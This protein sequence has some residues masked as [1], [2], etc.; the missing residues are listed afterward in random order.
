LAATLVTS[1]VGVATFLV[2]SA[3]NHGSIAPDW[4][5]GIALG[6]GGLVGGYLGAMAQP[7]LPDRIIRRTLGVLVVAIGSRYAYLA[8]KD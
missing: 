7:H 6:A 1:V 4:G 8:A 2:L 3:S 5:I